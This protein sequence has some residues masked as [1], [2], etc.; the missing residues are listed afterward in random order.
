MLDLDLHSGCGSRSMIWDFFWCKIL[1]FRLSE[2]KSTKNP[3]ITG[4]KYYKWNEDDNIAITKK[5]L[6]SESA[7][8]NADPNPPPSPPTN[9][10]KNTI[11]NIKSLIS[12]QKLPFNIHSDFKCENFTKISVKDPDPDPK[13]SEGRIRIRNDPPDRIRIRIRNNCFGSA[14]LCNTVI[15]LK[16][17]GFNSSL[18]VSKRRLIPSPLL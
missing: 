8:I 1:F 18:F 6:E 13:R 11:F 5:I 2:Y 17:T 15:P 7:L 9:N 14:T 4:E 12:A 16:K 10:Y 3:C